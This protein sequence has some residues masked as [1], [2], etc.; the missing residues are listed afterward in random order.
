MQGGKIIAIGFAMGFA[1]NTIMQVL[2]G[3]K[4]VPGKVFG[5]PFEGGSISLENN[6]VLLGVGY[7]I[8][9]RIAGI[10]FAGGALSYLVLIPMI[11]FFGSGLTEPLA[12]ATKL[13]SEMGIQ[14]KNSIQ[15]DYILYIGSG[16]GCCRRHYQS[17]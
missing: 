17:L 15:G 6:P 12:P 14:G 7:I 2:K 11:K 5:R 4:E 8:G 16:C 1:F 10:M 3:W 9:P 13:I